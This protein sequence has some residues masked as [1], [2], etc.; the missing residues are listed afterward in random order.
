MVRIRY[1]TSGYNRIIRIPAI[2]YSKR[3]NLRSEPGKAQTCLDIG[4]VTDGFWSHYIVKPV[5]T[6]HTDSGPVI[7][8][9]LTRIGDQRLTERLW[10][11][12]KTFK[13]LKREKYQEGGDLKARFIYKNHRN[14][15]G[16]LWVPS[17]AE[18]Y[19]PAGVLAGITEYRDIRVNNNVADSEFR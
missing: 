8:L 3:E 18:T 9:H 15:D 13:L 10:I 1:I 14:V 11:D 16:V 7:V 5:D 4:I 19:S 17:R 12:G 6:E 2:R